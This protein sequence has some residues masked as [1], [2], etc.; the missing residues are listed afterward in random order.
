MKDL[1]Y[2][3]DD[4]IATITL[5]RPESRNAYSSAMAESLIEAL[6]DAERRKQVRCVVVTGAGSAFCAGGDIKA[7]RDKSGMFSGDPVELR[8]NYLQGLQRVPRRFESFEKP[9]IAAINGPAVGAGLDLSLMCDIRIADPDAVFG[10]TFA[11]VGV[12]PGDGGVYLLSRVVGFSRAVELIL[13]ARIIDADEAKDIGLITEIADDSPLDAA[14]EK[15]ER[16]CSL[17]PKAIKTAKAALYRCVDHDLETSLQITAALQACVQRTD[18]HF[19]AVE[20]VLEQLDG[21]S[22]PS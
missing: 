2:E 5:D 6:D 14:Y 9:V 7:M 3:V 1:K 21:N 17:P 4:Q 22:G 18:E 10:S 16:I 19:E 8:D 20:S 12:I 11:K 15:A 13:T